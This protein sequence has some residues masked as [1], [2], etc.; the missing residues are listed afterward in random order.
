[1]KSESR[2]GLPAA[3]AM[4]AL[5]GAG[6]GM[7]R[8][9]R[10]RVERDARHHGPVGSKRV[11]ILG[12][13]FGG[14]TVALELAK[15]LPDS[16]RQVMMID[17]VNFHL[18]TPMLYQ[19]ATGLLEPGNI[20]YSVRSLARDHG[21]RFHEAE[22]VGID[23][24]R[25]IVA[26]DRGEQPYDL[27]VLALGSVT[28]F[29][30]NAAIQEHAVSL[31]NLRDAVTIRNR[32]LDAFERSD[33]EQD[34]DA[35]RALLT[36]VVVG[37]GATGVELTGSIRTLV[38]E[39]LLRDYPTISRS[40]VRLVLVEAGP[41]ILGGMDPWLAE[42][43][44]HHLRRQGIEVLLNHAAT[45][46]TAE[47]IRLEDGTFIPSKTVVWAA[48]VRP[49]PLTASLPIEKG[50]DGRLVV[51]EYLQVKG[52]SGVYA[53]GDCAWFSIASD[54]GKPAPPNAATATREARVVAHNVAAELAGGERQ[55]YEYRSE[56]NLVA[57]GQGDAVA[58]LGG[59]KVAGFPAWLIW[60]AFYLGQLMGFKDRLGVL[61][62]WSTA[63]FVR[64]DTAKLDV[65]VG[66]S[67]G[68]DREVLHTQTA[69]SGP[70][71]AGESASGDRAASR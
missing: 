32:I 6:Y 8:W 71:V 30:G 37:G 68:E 18:F 9:F 49:S 66:P 34:P 36:F 59:Y 65:G 40:D 50:R 53:V 39:G 21:F 19:V 2:S 62:D 48:G 27:L 26:T 13:G 28:N 57:L 31:K 64:R 41:S 45:D 70:V 15:L 11:L 60:R 63:Y 22:A 3:V 29:F 5:L 24:E 7:A 33:V 17:R 25:R 58:D 38:S 55:R 44:V 69:G 47:G 23:L 42:T 54:G 46:V 12:A 35:R 20:V 10:T 52:A 56:G 61:L 16:T 67:L 14:L 43:A 51:N 1:M 4:G